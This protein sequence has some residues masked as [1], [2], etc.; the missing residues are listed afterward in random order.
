MKA[1]FTLSYLKQKPGQL[2]ANDGYLIKSALFC[3]VLMLILTSQFRATSVQNSDVVAAIIGERLRVAMFFIAS[4]EKI[5][6]QIA[7]SGN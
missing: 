1:S 3:V 2:I 4:L 7:F 6:I 5:I